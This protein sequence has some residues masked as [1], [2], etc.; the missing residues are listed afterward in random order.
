MTELDYLIGKNWYESTQFNPNEITPEQIKEVIINK[1]PTPIWFRSYS[2]Y[3]TNLQKY[4]KSR[5]EGKK[6]YPNPLDDEYL[7]K[8]ILPKMPLHGRRKI[9][10]PEIKYN[11]SNSEWWYENFR[12]L[13]NI[14]ERQYI[15]KKVRESLKKDK[16]LPKGP[17]HSWLTRLIQFINTY[18]AEFYL[19][20]LLQFKLDGKNHDCLH[21][22]IATIEECLPDFLLDENGNYAELKVCSESAFKSYRTSLEKEFETTMKND[23]HKKEGINVVGALFIIK[24]SPL[25]IYSIDLTSYEEAQH[26]TDKTNEVD[27]SNLKLILSEDKGKVPSAD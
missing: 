2:F 11:W 13:L 14:I 24:G 7:R 18:E 5:T 21:D 10:I 19:A 6:F 12:D 23:F 20:D 8:Y 1:S 3:E 26:Y 17:Y 25:K 16:Y 4:I 27:L 22:G 9:A 15:K